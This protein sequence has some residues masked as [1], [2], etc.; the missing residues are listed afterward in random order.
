MTKATQN[1]EVIKQYTLLA[2]KLDD[3][4]DE[5]VRSMASEVEKTAAQVKRIDD[6]A[7]VETHNA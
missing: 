5:C 6:I 2:A 3:L 4:A 1:A 7:R